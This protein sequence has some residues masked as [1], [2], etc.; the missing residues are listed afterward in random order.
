MSPLPSAS[1]YIPVAFLMTVIGGAAFAA[2]AAAMVFE[3]VN[4]NGVFDPGVDRD[5]TRE[6]DQEYVISSKEVIVISGGTFKTRKSTCRT[7]G[8][9]PTINIDTTKDVHINSNLDAGIWGSF[10]TI[11]SGGSIT[12]AS[13]V[14]INGMTW[15]ELTA[16]KGMVIGDNV[17]LKSSG[18]CDH[19]FAMVNLTASSLKIGSNVT[20]YGRRTI[21]L[22]ATSGGP[23]G[24]V[25]VG[26]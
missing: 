21:N 4:N 26:P 7:T 9:C 6:L 12:V 14:T 25:A 3:D 18:L 8:D 22:H 5:R 24:E 13:N 2:D 17:N 19:L 23:I 10:I 20:M 1:R 11:T 16:A 15:V